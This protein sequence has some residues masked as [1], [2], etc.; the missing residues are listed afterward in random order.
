MEVRRAR[1]DDWEALRE[2]RLAALADSPDA[3]GSTFAEERDADEA[4]WQGW[5]TGKGWDGDVATFV[6]EGADP[7]IG[8]ATGFRPNDR[9][10]TG[11]L[12]AMWVRPERRGEGIGRQLVAV[13]AEWAAALDIDQLLLH[14]TDGNDGAVRFYA[15]CGF[16]GT[17]DAPE[18]LREGSDL[19]VKTMRLL[20]GRRSDE[21]LVRSQIEYYDDRA[22]VYEDLWFRRGTHDR[23]PWV[24]EQWFAETAIVE[25]DLASVDAS[26]DVLELA[27]GSGL[28]TRFLAPRARRLVAVDASPRM[29]DLNR[30]HVADP[31]VD[32]RQ[33]D[34]FSWDTAERFDLIVTGFF[35]SHVP[36]SR[37]SDFWAK[38]ARWLRVGG[39]VWI[40]DDATP[41]AAPP[42]DTPSVGGPLH[43]HR[44]V[45]GDCEYTIVKLFYE[46][47]VL[48]RWLDEIGWESN[49]RRT[50][51][52][53]LVG[54][55]RPRLSEHS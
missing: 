23:G 51:E 21:D 3:F 39:L 54:S 55:A 53:F 16:V 31:H 18:P 34:L 40:V 24:N 36:P 45:I 46:P 42:A 22:P 35:V 1:A 29:L 37:F 50:G 47:D 11:W 32:Y 44:R 27:C 12:F 8:M 15:S 43:A 4:R 38:V 20:L 2:I 9:P 30:S 48:T 25:A 14:V 6:A 13:V 7:L 52:H 26:G 10:T 49:L 17:S 28:W 41:L 33:A 5:V 19:M